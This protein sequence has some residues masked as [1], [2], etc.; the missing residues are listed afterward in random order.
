MLQDRRNIDNFYHESEECGLPGIGQVPVA[1]KV[2][3]HVNN[4]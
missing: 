2:E 4:P 1:R 3:R